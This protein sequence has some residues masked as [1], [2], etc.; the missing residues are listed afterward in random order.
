MASPPTTYTP[1][2][3]SPCD[4]NFK[5]PSGNAFVGQT[6]VA[7]YDCS[8]WTCDSEAGG[9]MTGD[10]EHVFN[11]KAPP[12]GQGWV[13]IGNGTATNFAAASFPIITHPCSLGGALRLNACSASPVMLLLQVARLSHMYTLRSEIVTAV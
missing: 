4:V 2:P 9:H 5:I 11:R 6:V 8:V 12:K 10:S 13:M 1:T 7:I 3:V